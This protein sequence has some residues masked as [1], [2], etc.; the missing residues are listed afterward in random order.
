MN[1]DPVPGLTAAQCH[2]I[3]DR[4]A[5]SNGLFIGLDF[6]GTLAPIATDPS[7][8]TI[9]PSCKRALEALKSHPRARVAVIS[10]RQLADLRSRVNIRGIMYA[11][12][13]GLELEY[14]GVTETH[15]RTA[16]YR[17][18]IRH[19]INTI[20]GRLADI[21]GWTIEDKGLTATI[22]FRQTPSR[23]IPQ[24][25]TAI[26]TAVRETGTDLRISSGK[27]VFEI[28]PPI[29]WDKGRLMIR[30]AGTLP[31]GWQTMYVGDDTTDEDAFRAIQ[32][33]GV[34][35]HVGTDDRTDALY[36][37][38]AQTAVAPFLTWL[39]DGVLDDLYLTESIP[40]TDD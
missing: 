22:H 4:L 11:G 35:I 24:I 13:H 1:Q 6:D 26:E 7:V 33:D 38:P 25:R 15:P 21:P 30:L 2:D 39:A 3:V 27:Q 29:E 20:P 17:P 31:E 5:E 9:T 19:I 40:T 14:R 34:G 23:W 28:R 36:C 32:P 37:L 10:G 8:P 12:N 18:V 16:H